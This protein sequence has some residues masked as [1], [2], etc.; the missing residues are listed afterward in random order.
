MA[1]ITFSLKDLQDLVGKKL[2]IEEVHD[3]AHYGK[4][5]VEAYDQET[6]EVKIN[7][8]DTNLPYLWSVEGF[9]RLLKGILELQ[10]GIPELKLNKGDYRVIVDKSITK[11]RPFIACFAAKGRRLDDYLLKQIIQ[12]QEKF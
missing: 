5:E 9:A 4:A 12:L 6:G 10:K 3:L 8:E 2:K 7:F 1:T 11:D